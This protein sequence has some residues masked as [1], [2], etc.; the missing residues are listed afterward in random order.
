MRFHL[1]H[2]RDPGLEPE[3]RIHDLAWRYEIEGYNMGRTVFPKPLNKQGPL[4]TVPCP[5]VKDD[6]GLRT[7]SEH[8]A[9]EAMHDFE[10]I[11]LRPSVSVH[12]GGA[13]FTHE[14]LIAAYE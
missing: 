1:F 13:E 4:F 3:P 6:L 10:G 11:L 2:L 5:A 14:N 12:V 8:E 7:S 9:E